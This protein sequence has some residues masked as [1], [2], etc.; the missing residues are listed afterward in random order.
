M[1]K[2]LVKAIFLLQICVNFDME[3]PRFSCLA[4]VQVLTLTNAP[5]SD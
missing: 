1:M 3:H 5:H 4:Q 2:L